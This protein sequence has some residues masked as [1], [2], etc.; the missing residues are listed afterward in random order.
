MAVSLFG[1]FQGK[2]AESWGL[3]LL[4]FLVSSLWPTPGTHI[5]QLAVG[6]DTGKKD[7]FPWEARVVPKRDI[8]ACNYI[9]QNKKPQLEHSAINAGSIDFCPA[10][11]CLINSRCSYKP[12]PALAFPAMRDERENSKDWHSF[13]LWPFIT[14]KLQNPCN[15]PCFPPSNPRFGYQHCK[16]T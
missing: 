2:E 6:T 15:L 11:S 3:F 4:R 13:M 7:L 16:A 9:T 12:V 14:T 10:P 8:S 5:P 1:Q